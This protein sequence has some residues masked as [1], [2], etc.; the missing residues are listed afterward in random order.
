[1]LTRFVYDGDALVQEFNGS[2]TLL[3]RY[4]HGTELG[5]DPLAWF[6]GA[7]FSSSQQRL[8]RSDHQGSI[9]AVA[10]ATSANILAINTYDEYGRQGSSNQGRFQ[11]TGQA[12]FEEL[13]LYY[14]KA[15][16]CSGTLGRFM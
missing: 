15:R 11:Y 4:V 14:Y 13:G 9:V 1:G 16:M 7:G 10:D 8:L 3:R 6:E 5:D 2:G 12:W